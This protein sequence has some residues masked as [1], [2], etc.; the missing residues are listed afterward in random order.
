MTLE[1]LPICQKLPCKEGKKQSKVL[2]GELKAGPALEQESDE[3]KLSRMLAEA[4]GKAALLEREAH[5]QGFRLGEEA[6]MA[7]GRKRAEHIV[8]LME[9]QLAAMQKELT[10]F[11]HQ[12]DQ[13]V[14]DFSELV[15]SQFLGER[16]QDG[17]LLL[18][19]LRH[20]MSEVHCDVS[21][22]ILVNEDDKKKLDLLLDADE[23][24]PL[25]TTADLASGEARLLVQD[26]VV[27]VHLDQFLSKRFEAIRQCLKHEFAAH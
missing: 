26:A 5:E 8:C 15:L 25:Q 27:T 10:S 23:Q 9:Q 12:L 3:V 16:L 1:P 6:G 21:Y 22:R 4:Q 2:W 17:H 18:Q 19:A 20:A 14:I 24:L 11:Y 13:Q 7:L